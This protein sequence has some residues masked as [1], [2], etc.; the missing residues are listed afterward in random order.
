LSITRSDDD[1]HTRIR[2]LAVYLSGAQPTIVETFVTETPEVI[3][4]LI[5]SARAGQ[6][7]VVR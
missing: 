2:G 5:N 1:T 6:R 3:A 7:F 4:Q